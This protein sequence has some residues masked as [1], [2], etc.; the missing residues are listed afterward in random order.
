M[1]LLLSVEVKIAR[2][3]I[4][5]PQM[6]KNSRQTTME[7][8]YDLTVNRVQYE[9]QALHRSDKTV[10]REARKVRPNERK[11]NNSSNT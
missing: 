5:T 11:P 10:R 4:K 6:R 9:D 3:E 7:T 2:G 1:R 8:E